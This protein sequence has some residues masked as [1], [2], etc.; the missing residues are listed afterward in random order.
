MSD[1][2]NNKSQKLSHQHLNIEQRNLLYQP[3]Q[4]GNLSQRQM[5]VLLGCHQSTTKG[6]IKK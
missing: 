1:Q 5:A 6:I 2:C 4:E 3:S